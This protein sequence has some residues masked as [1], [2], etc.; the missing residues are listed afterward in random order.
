MSP[1]VSEVGAKGPKMKERETQKRRDLKGSDWRKKMERRSRISETEIV[2]M[3]IGLVSLLL[4]WVSGSV[5]EEVGWG[6]DWKRNLGL[7]SS[8]KN[9][10]FEVDESLSLCLCLSLSLS[11]LKID[12]FR[13]F[14]SAQLD[15][16]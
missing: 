5:V 4:W 13:T 10:I 9:S 3:R 12:R 15:C 16:Y 8:S 2:R 6:R 1:P 14:R 7:V 11:A